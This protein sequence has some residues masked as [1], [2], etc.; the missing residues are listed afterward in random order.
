MNASRSEG[1]VRLALAVSV[2]APNGTLTADP[3]SLFAA[4][5][6]LK[7]VGLEADAC[8]LAVEAALAAGL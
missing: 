7:A 1:Q 6:G 8:R 2:A 3:V 4:A 5:S